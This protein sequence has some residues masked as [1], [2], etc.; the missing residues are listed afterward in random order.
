MKEGSHEDDNASCPWTWL[1]KGKSRIGKKD[2]REMKK[3][4]SFCSSSLSLPP[5]HPR[6]IL[7]PRAC[8]FLRFSLAL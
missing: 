2:E 7:V 3:I 6:G 8:T 4:S 5:W 1:L